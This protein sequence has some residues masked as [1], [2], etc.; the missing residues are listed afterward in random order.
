M[1]NLLTVSDIPTVDPDFDDLELLY[2]DTDADCVGDFG[3]ELPLASPHEQR[4]YDFWL[5]WDERHQDKLDRR[6]V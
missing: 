3:E 5:Q 4:L 2:S 6:S 1:I